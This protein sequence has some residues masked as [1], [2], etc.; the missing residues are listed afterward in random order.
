M[1]S[2]KASPA[3]HAVFVAE[4]NLVAASTMPSMFVWPRATLSSACECVCVCVCVYARVCVCVCV[5]ECVDECCEGK[6]RVLVGE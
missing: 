6:V 2:Q 1:L 4:A 3:K 5:D